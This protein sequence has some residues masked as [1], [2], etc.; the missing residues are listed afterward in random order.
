M[1]RLV[2]IVFVSL[3]VLIFGLVHM[4]KAEYSEPPLEYLMNGVVREM[5]G[6]W[7]VAYDVDNDGDWDVSFLHHKVSVTRP[8][9]ECGE[10]LRQ[11]GNLYVWS[12]CDEG[13]TPLLYTLNR[14]YLAV[15]KPK[16]KWSWY[17]KSTWP[18]GEN[19]CRRLYS[20]AELRCGR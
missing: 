18:S 16:Q 11:G 1:K 8:Y 17:I 20:F 19:G 3:V 2:F 13:Q 4:A 15:R 7:A 5:A 14:K 6:N 12:G 9:K 10:P